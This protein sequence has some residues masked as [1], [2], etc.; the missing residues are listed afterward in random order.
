MYRNP[1]IC[2]HIP[3]DLHKK[4]QNLYMTMAAKRALVRLSERGTL[5]YFADSGTFRLSRGDHIS[6]P[7]GVCLV[8]AGN[9][10]LIKTGTFRFKIWLPDMDSNHD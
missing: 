3:G 8:C 7:P 1:A 4:W 2:I 6:K 9:C 10:Q 5:V